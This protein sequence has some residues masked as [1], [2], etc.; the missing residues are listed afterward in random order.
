MLDPATS[1]DALVA[2]F[3]WRIPARF[4]IATACC[5]VWAEAEPERPAVIDVR[6]DGGTEVLTF[7]ALRSAANRLANALR[8]RGV[9]AGDRIA[10]MLPQGPHVPVAH[11]AAYKLG[12]IAVP[13]ANLFG[14]DAI[15]YRLND[16]GA[17]ALVTNAAGLAKARVAGAS[18][19]ILSTDG[20]DGAALGLDAVC[21]DEPATFAA[22]DTRPDDPAMMIYTS[23]TTGQP[24]G[25]L[26]GHRVLLGHLPGVQMPHEF[27]P[28]PGDRLW[29]PADWAWAG[30]LLN[31]LLPGLYFGVPVIAR[32]FEKFDPEAAFDLI[33]RQG[34][35]NSF[36][37]P[38]ALRML[39]QVRAPG[40]RF[41]MNLRT[42]AS[43]GEALGEETFAWGREALG[44]SINEFYGQTECNLVIASCAAIGVSRPGSMGRP[45]PGHEVRH[46]ARGTGAGCRPKAGPGDVPDLLEPARGDGGEVHRRLDDDRRP[47]PC[48]C[49]RIHP[50]RR[51]G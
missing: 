6:P 24:K 30:G 40:E 41:H 9:V 44:L 12:C 20:A 26:H 39:R 23:G 36:V 19:L 15:A 34:V 28:Q 47:G 7:G 29:T 10:I 14:V 42:L 38:T 25:A 2:G 46:P 33:A 43:G 51:P 21:A 11:M 50:L 22:A 18:L 8:R 27:L 16:S 37:P 45:V 3:R 32:K 17:A 31:I 49:G 13:L 5:D 1:H 48:G 35:R 4:N